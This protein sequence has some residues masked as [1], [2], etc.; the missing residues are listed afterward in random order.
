MELLTLK[1]GFENSIKSI[2]LTAIEAKLLNYLMRNELKVL[3]RGDVL[4]G[5]WGDSVHITERSVD[6]YVSLLRKKCAPF[7]SH[8]ESDLLHHLSDE[9]LFLIPVQFPV[10]YQNQKT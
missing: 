8:F 1:L 7:E 3:A 5:V 6:T 9:F 10:I 2:L 4:K